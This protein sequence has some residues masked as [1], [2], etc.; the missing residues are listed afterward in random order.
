MR[1]TKKEKEQLCDVLEYYNDLMMQFRTD[2]AA[3]EIEIIHAMYLKVRKEV[4]GF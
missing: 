1:F 3:D 2:R 4:K